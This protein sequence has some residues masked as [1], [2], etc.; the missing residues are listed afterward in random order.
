MAATVDFACNSTRPGSIARFFS[1]SGYWPL[2][3]FLAA[4][5]CSRFVCSAI[6]PLAAYGLACGP[7]SR[8]PALSSPAGVARPGG[9]LVASIRTEPRSF[10]RLAARDSSTDLVATLTQAR[11]VRINKQTQ[12]VEP[13]L[14]ERWTPSEEGR[15]VTLSLR[16]DVTFSDGHPF[17][18]DDV[19]FTFEALYDP[20]NAGPLADT[21]QVGGKKLEVAASDAHTIAITF[22]APFAPGV[23]LLDN[24]PILPRHKLEPA[25][26]N[27]TFASAWGLSTPPADIVG[28]GPFVLSEYVPGQRLV[29]SRNPRYW[30]TGADGTRLPFLDRLVVEIIPDQNAELLRLTAGQLDVT[31]G[32]IAPESYATVKHAADEGRV[33]IIDLGVSSDADSFWFNL[34]PGAFAADPRA[35]WIQ[36]DELRRAIS[37][38]VDRQAF[39]DTVF[40]GA[41]EP[42]YGP[43]TPANKAWYWAGTPRVPHDPGAAKAML[44]AIGL[45]DRNGDGTLDD[46]TGRLVRF[47]IVTQKGR[48][49]LERGAAVIRDDLKAIGVTVDVVALDG[50]ALVE[51]IGNGKY[52]AMY[53]RASATDTDP[54]LTPDFWFS[55]GSAHLWNIGEA[56]PATE[57]E[58]RIDALMA[59]QSASLDAAERKRLFDDVQRIFSEHVPVLYFAAPRV[60]VATSARVLN[61]TPGLVTLTPL[62]WAPDT[63]AVVH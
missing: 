40:L 14:A 32:E 54:A 5:K 26:K 4:S 36:R 56:K 22:P 63:L 59:R 17:T 16:R 10:N 47:A 39:A 2:G 19:L 46:P 12:D 48:P 6:L 20:R 34:K 52:D 1:R 8:P 18:A 29:F 61:A 35:P 9:E 21:L 44:E 42:V 43:E 49:R 13:W 45:R 28:L 57:W 3:Q 31:N 53:F 27:G 23:R 15:R 25:Q 30:R 62:L 38:A 51:R 60:V 7:S 58:A 11:L 55:S 41:G 24:L 33:R 37:L 50:P